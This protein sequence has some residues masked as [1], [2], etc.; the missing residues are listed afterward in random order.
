MSKS[1]HISVNIQ[2]ALNLPYKKFAREYDDVFSDDDGTPIPTKEARKFMKQEL[3]QGHRLIRS[4]GCDNFD[5]IKGC[6]GHE[7]VS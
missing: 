3:K 4:K 2:G 6:L 7:E 1:F 5:P